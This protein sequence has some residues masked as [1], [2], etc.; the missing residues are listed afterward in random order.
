MR[1]ASASRRS[2]GCSCLK[3]ERAMADWPKGRTGGRAVPRRALPPGAYGGKV[4]LALSLSREPPL[5][6]GERARAWATGARRVVRA[7]G[8]RASSCPAWHQAVYVL[9]P[10]SPPRPSPRDLARLDR[11]SR[12]L[13]VGA[14]RSVCGPGISIAVSQCWYKAGQEGVESD[15]LTRS[16]FLARQRPRARRS[17]A[18]HSCS[19]GPDQSPLSVHAIH[20]VPGTR[21]CT[22]FCTRL[23]KKT[24][25]V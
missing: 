3:L 16:C 6:R 7:H 11:L 22:R 9:R 23:K 4:A 2:C 25:C 13:P 8:T 24:R 20:L 12:K 1:C 19:R 18:W 15:H 14:L 17:R 10:H 5:L 21:Y